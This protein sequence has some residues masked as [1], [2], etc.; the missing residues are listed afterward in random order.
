M[1]TTKT[2]RLTF[3]DAM[4]EMCEANL[5]VKEEVDQY[6]APL[7]A[8]YVERTVISVFDDSEKN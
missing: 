3:K 8:Q 1:T 7:S 4:N 6:Q 2:L 5:F